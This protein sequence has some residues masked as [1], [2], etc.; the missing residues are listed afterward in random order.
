MG[1]GIIYVSTL[2]TL[3]F[4]R[5]GTKQ[6]NNRGRTLLE[7]PRVVYRRATRNYNY[8]GCVGTVFSAENLALES[9]PAAN[10]PEKRPECSLRRVGFTAAKKGGRKIFPN[11]TGGGTKAP[12]WEC[13]RGCVVELLGPG[14]DVALFFWF[15]AEMAAESER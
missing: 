10:D 13:S 7:P 6:P 3:F 5:T 9:N 11:L 2:K 1:F 12:Q 8:V 15:A 4:L 14:G